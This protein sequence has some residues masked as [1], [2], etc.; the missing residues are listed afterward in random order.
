MDTLKSRKEFLA[1]REAKFYKSHFFIAQYEKNNSQKFL[2]GLTVSKKNGNAVK[3]NFIKRRLREAVRLTFKKHP[4]TSV[5]LNFIPRY[6]LADCTFEH[7][8]TETERFF[9]TL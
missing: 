3:R 2:Y 1:L 8:L 6:T 9:K 5:K 4:K 7:L